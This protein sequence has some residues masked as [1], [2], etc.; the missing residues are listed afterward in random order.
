MGTSFSQT[1]MKIMVAVPK[2]STQSLVRSTH[3]TLLQVAMTARF[4]HAPIKH[5]PTTKSL[6]IRF[7]QFSPLI[8]ELLKARLLR[9]EGIRKT[10]TK[11]ETPGK[12]YGSSPRI[13]IS[14]NVEFCLAQLKDSDN[15]RCRY[16]SNLAAAEQLYDAL[17][18]WNRIGSLTISA[19]SLTFFQDF[20]SSVTTGTYSASSPTYSTLT[21][22][23]KTYADGYMSIVQ[24]YTPS[25][26][27]LAEQFSRTDG[28]PLSAIDLTWSY[29]AF[30]TAVAARNGQ[31]PTSWGEASGNAVPSSCSATSAQGTYT[32]PTA[33]AP[34]PPCPTVTSVAVTF[35]VAEATNPGETVLV[36]GSIS[37]LGTWAAGSAIALSA[38][39][40]ASGYPRWYVTVDIPAG[41]AFEYKYL[42]KEADDSFTWE[43]DPNRSFSVP[44]GCAAEVELHDT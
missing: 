23:I 34:L 5:W 42:K 11:A 15:C 31:V 10:F 41:T 25:T 28:A 3:L 16:L 21:S 33:T 26:G 6:Q 19:T 24:Q 29:A 2:M 44:E 17:Y 36:A 9:W 22:A 14:N 7:G 18:Q 37:Q 39:D 43:D 8:P 27:A 13:K 1:S 38:N 12:Y 35:N 20:L 40:Y 30:L 4:S 32:A